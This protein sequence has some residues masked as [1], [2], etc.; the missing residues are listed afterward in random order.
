MWPWLRARVKWRQK[1]GQILAETAVKQRSKREARGGHLGW[2]VGVLRALCGGGA[3]GPRIPGH[4]VAQGDDRRPRGL[5]G[6]VGRARRRGGGPRGAERVLGALDRRR[7]RRAVEAR[8]PVVNAWS[9]R[10]QICGQRGRWSGA[11]VG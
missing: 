8:L 2:A 7:A 11:V 9:K 1:N 6:R 5:G 3:V 4:R 10:V